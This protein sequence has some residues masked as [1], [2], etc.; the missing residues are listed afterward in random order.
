ME[1]A[2]LYRK[3]MGIFSSVG[4]ES[5]KLEILSYGGAYDEKQKKYRQL[6]R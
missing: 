1:S 2:D 4:I 3:K 5:E 6:Q